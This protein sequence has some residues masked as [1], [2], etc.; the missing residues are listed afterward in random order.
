M[1]FLTVSP[2]SRS[3]SFAEF[4]D[5]LL[6]LPQKASASEI[7]RYYEMRK[8][9]GEDARGTARVTMEGAYLSSLSFGPMAYWRAVGDVS[10]SAEDRPTIQ[11]KAEPTNAH[12]AQK[13]DNGHPEAVSEDEE[14]SHGWLEGHSAM[15]FLLAGG[16]AG[17][18]ECCIIL[19]VFTSKSFI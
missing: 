13:L 4:R 18:G 19:H 5:F 17:A 11:L 16:I 6:L 8:Y 3:I 15:K 12:N 2:H 1:T 9:L 14:D 10:L 7:Y